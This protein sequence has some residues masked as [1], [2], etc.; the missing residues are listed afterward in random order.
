MQGFEFRV[1]GKG[2]VQGLGLL[3]WGLG[4]EATPIRCV[5]SAMGYGGRP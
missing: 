4:F 1:R 5:P 2:N 3:A